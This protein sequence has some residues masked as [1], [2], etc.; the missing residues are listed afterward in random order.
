MGTPPLDG[1]PKKKAR[2]DEELVRQ[3]MK[4]ERKSLEQLLRRHQ[5]WIYNVALRMTAD[6]QDAEDVTQEIL[7]IVITKLDTFEG[8]SRFR[9]W[10]YRIVV[11]YV[12]NM[13]KKK[14]EKLLYS[15]EQYGRGIDRSP[16]LD[17]PDP[18]S[19]PVELP[20]IL[21]EIK[22]FCMM[23][24]LLCLNREQRLIFI[25][26]EVLGVNDIVGSEIFGITK[27][28]FRKKLSRA[29]KSV[30]GFMKERCGLVYETNSCHCDMKAKGLID[31]GEVKPDCLRFANS[32]S[33]N[34]SALCAE[35]YSRFQDYLNSRCRSLF[36]DQP[37]MDPPDYVERFREMLNSKEL[38]EIIGTL[39]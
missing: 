12:I 19:L 21:E 6:P 36:R 5:G 28:N 11:N 37:F 39:K 35:R 31:R 30:Y 16:N 7:L 9:T 3:A 26:G 2:P 18:K 15:F 32:G 1:K 17:L 33:P 23:G 13:K 25:L 4:G 29:R 22:I 20:L 10:V 8:R 14:T 24:M 34:C 38:Q 27:V